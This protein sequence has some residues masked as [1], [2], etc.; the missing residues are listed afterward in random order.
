MAAPLTADA[1]VRALRAEG[2]RITEHAGWRGHNRNHKG[3][4]GPVHGVMLH[5][6]AGSSS[7]G[8]CRRGAPE[9]PGPLCVGVI[10]KDGAVHLIGYGRTN[11]AGS[12]SSAVLAAVRE[13]L[14]L[15][16]PG[17]D[18]VDGN[19]RFYGFE[20][21]NL[22][23]GRDP[24]PAA[25]LDAVERLSAALCRVHGWS[26]ASVIGHKEWTR[27]KIDPSFSMTGMRSRI[28]GRLG[29]HPV[30]DPPPAPVYAPF[31]GGS[32]FV[33]GHRDPLFTA[34]GK[35]LVAEGCGR[36]SVG[37]GPV[38]GAADRNSYAAWQRKLGYRGTDA[39][40]TPGRDS[41]QRLHVPRA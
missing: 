18:A 15:P 28:A 41:W 26:A 39:D 35:R 20:I 4:W 25:Q 27:R 14:P 10:A 16:A 21:E 2:V 33:P 29:G 19:A 17:P 11:H 6:T 23:S 36:Y 1:F 13:E 5:H 3:A 24:Y 40:G 34:V 8:Y 31:P 32:F 7:V 12:G 9:L 37:P 30:T 38:W 22:G